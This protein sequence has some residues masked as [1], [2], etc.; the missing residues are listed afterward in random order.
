MDIKPAVDTDLF[1]E[2]ELLKKKVSSGLLPD[3]LK[4][5]AFRMIKRLQRMAKF[6]GYS[7]EYEKVNHYINW[8]L[9]LPWFEETEDV[10]DLDRA[11]EIMNQNH[12]GMNDVKERILEYLSVL[13]LRKDKGGVSDAPILC[14]VG[15]VGTGKTTFGF[16]LAEAMGRKFIRIPFGGLGSLLDLR[17]QSRA[18]PDSQPGQIIKALRRCGSKNP[19]F[20]L[21]EIDRVDENARANI[22]GVLVE[23][24]DPEQNQFFTDYYLDYPFDL[25][26]VLFLAT[27]NNTGNIATAVLD[28]MEVIQMPSYTDEEKTVIAKEYI[29][30]KALKEAGLEEGTLA[31]DD[32]LWPLI[33][34]PLGFDAG[35]RSLERNIQRISR[36]VAKM[37]V[38]GKE[39][40]FHL[41]KDNIKEFLPSY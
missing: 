6:G 41:R 37:F 1:E 39:K 38:L 29:L 26:K 32:D 24:L 4:D 15:L 17:G 12:Y 36:K 28:R 5:K 31:I 30:P 10:L 27:C 21:D 19:V 16:S 8:I 34:R 35:M 13:K 3:D 40:H 2:V 9:K 33:V 11:L 18:H 7:S 14:L 25:S 23:L 22:M 20:M